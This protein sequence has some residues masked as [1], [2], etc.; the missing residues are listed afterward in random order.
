MNPTGMVSYSA[1][2]ASKGA[3]AALLHLLDGFVKAVGTVGKHSVLLR[4]VVA[5]GESRTGS[6]QRRR[7]RLHDG[8]GKG[9]LI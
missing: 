3:E 2:S 7:D 6:S 1:S 8:V 4:N 9:A 5:A